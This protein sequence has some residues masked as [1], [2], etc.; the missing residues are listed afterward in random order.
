MRAGVA[1]ASL[2]EGG[3][4]RSACAPEQVDPPPRPRVRHERGAMPCEPCRHRA[5]KGVDAK[6]HARDEIVDLADPKQVPGQE[7]ALRTKLAERVADD[8]VHLLLGAAKRA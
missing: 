1:G 4:I 7:L 3:G 2:Y 6:L 5:V 8:L